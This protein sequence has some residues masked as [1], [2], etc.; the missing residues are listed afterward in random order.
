MNK[1]DVLCYSARFLGRRAMNINQIH[2]NLIQWIENEQTNKV[3]VDEMGR[4]IG[5]SRD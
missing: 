2:K 3:E 1:N 4:K 5:G